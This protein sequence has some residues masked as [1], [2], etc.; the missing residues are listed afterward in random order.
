MSNSSNDKVFAGSIPKLYE[1]YL[2]PLIFE[3][4]AADIANRLI[5]R[6]IS[7]VLEVA[8]GTGVVT[9]SL[10]SALPENVS[11]TATDL[12]QA[13][14]DQASSIGKKR[15]VEWRQADSMQLPFQNEMFDAVV[16]QWSYVL[17]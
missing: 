9:R 14:L 12:N 15:T 16:C 7:S 3:P 6:S 1:E 2:V 5:T 11:I 4:F 17:S 10:T 13:M 8:A